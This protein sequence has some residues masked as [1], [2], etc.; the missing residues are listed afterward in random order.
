MEE[1]SNILLTYFKV[2]VDHVVILV[3]ILM[4]LPLG[5]S[6][7]IYISCSTIAK[8]RLIGQLITNE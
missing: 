6:Y 1:V 4:E 3:P 5:F 8:A 7:Y 2:I